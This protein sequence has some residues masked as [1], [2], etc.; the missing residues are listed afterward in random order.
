MS[1]SKSQEPNNHRE[2][3]PISQKIYFGNSNEVNRLMYKDYNEYSKFTERRQSMKGFD[4]EYLDFVDYIIKITHRIWEEKGIGQIYNTYHNDV[5]MHIGTT[6]NQG[7]QEVISGTLQTLHAFPDRKLIGENVVWSGNDVEGFYS[8]HRNFSNAT[9][10]GDSQFGPATG[11]KAMF[12]TIVDCF[13]HSNRIVEEWLVRDNLAIVKQ[14]GF[15]PVETA[16]KLA[17]ASKNKQPALQMRSGVGDPMEGQLVPPLYEKQL[18]GFDI[19]DFI[20]DL[21]NKIW[22]WRLFNEVKNFYADT[23]TLHYICNKD[24]VG[25]QQIQSMLISLFASFPNAKFIVERV[26]CNQGV[27]EQEWDAAIRWRL[28]GIHEG[29]GSFG[30]P[31][32]EPVEIL[33]ISHLRIRDE[34]VVEEWLTFDGLDVLRQIYSSADTGEPQ[35]EKSEQEV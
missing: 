22:E 19:G 4:E 25:F 13:V 35:E 12:R 8:S 17:A 15:D 33:G 32:G 27:T 20:L 24:L 7:I 2:K 14:L 34:K 3:Q 11:K 30:Q 26:T 9:N 5:H 1:D 10:L 21:Y 31:S 23:A 6:K 29:L 16:K 28:Q 18:S